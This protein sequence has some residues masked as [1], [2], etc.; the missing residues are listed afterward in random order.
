[1]ILM[2]MCIFLYAALLLQ[3]NWKNVFV[4]VDVDHVCIFDHVHVS[5][6]APLLVQACIELYVTMKLINCYINSHVHVLC[7]VF[8]DHFEPVQMNSLTFMRLL[9]LI[10]SKPFFLIV[11]IL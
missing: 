6:V 5:N 7:C 2:F 1:M 10:K 3:C 11:G 9:Y 4:Y 8:H